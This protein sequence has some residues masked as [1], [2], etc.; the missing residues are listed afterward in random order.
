MQNR[1]MKDMFNLRL[2]TGLRDRIKEEA[3]SNRRSMNAEI[4]YHLE[5]AVFDNMEMKKGGEVSA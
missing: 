2:P 3:A 5:K 1:T 4:I